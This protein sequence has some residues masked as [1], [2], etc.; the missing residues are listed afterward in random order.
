MTL[1]P[2][3]DKSTPP[4]P[5]SPLWGAMAEPGEMVG[6]I[7]F[8]CGDKSYSYPYHTLS[9]WVLARGRPDSLEIAAGND[10]IK[11]LGQSLE[12]LRDALDAGVLKVLTEQADR[13]SVLHTDETTRIL[14]L[15]VASERGSR[16]GQ[17]KHIETER[18]R[19]DGTPTQPGKL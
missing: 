16:C 5:V 6:A 13:Y 3:I 14:S 15:I 10:T 4:K 11:V 1:K 17:D 12:K 18:E 2:Q 8:E 9:R 7:R 19:R